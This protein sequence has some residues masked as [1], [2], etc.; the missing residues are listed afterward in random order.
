MKNPGKALVVLLAAVLLAAV[1][2]GCGKNVDKSD[3]VRWINGTQALRAEVI[4]LRKLSMIPLSASSSDIPNERS[5]SSC[6]VLIR[7]IAAS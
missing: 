3:T 4:H 2:A 7:P 1:T 5:F 6:S